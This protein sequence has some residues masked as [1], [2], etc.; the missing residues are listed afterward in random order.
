M[1]KDWPMN[2][3]YGYRRIKD[4]YVCSLSGDFYFSQG[5]TCNVD[6]DNISSS[7]AKI[8]IPIS[9]PIN[10]YIKLKLSSKKM[11]TILIEGKVCWC[12]K[13]LGKYQAGILFNKALAVE[14]AMLVN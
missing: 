12:R 11:D 2:S 1:D 4:R 10:S 3:S 14:P 6:C 9:L 8:N 13:S 7:G 5:S